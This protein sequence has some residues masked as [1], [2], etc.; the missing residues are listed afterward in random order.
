MYPKNAPEG[1]EPKPGSGK[2]GQEPPKQSAE[3]KQP[4]G[5]EPEEPTKPPEPNKEPDDK[6]PDNKEPEQPDKPEK[7]DAPDG[8]N[9]TEEYVK[10]L[11]SEAASWRTKFQ[12]A[13]RALATVTTERD[14]LRTQIHRAEIKSLAVDM[15]AL[16]PEWVAD[17]V[18]E[19]VVKED[20]RKEAITALRKERPHLFQTRSINGG[21]KNQDLGG[22]E[23]V[24]SNR[25]RGAYEARSNSNSN[26]G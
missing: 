4:E 7:P 22:V 9:Y 20:K 11:R 18:A 6:E 26:R 14:Q 13:D 10:G 3:P 16:D 15:G 23:G 19:D 24:G 21:S 8:K 5:Q 17:K 12:T 1:Q 25:L 2:E